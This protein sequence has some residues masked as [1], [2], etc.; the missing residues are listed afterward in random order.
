[1]IQRKKAQKKIH[2]RPRGGGLTIGAGVEPPSSP[3]QAPQIPGVLGTTGITTMDRQ[4]TGQIPTWENPWGGG[5]WYDRQL[6]QIPT[7]MGASGAGRYDRMMSP[8]GIGDMIWG[9][10]GGSPW[11]P[12]G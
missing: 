5:G 11:G 3:E 9:M 4:Q 1:M 2:S 6:P 7:W 12:M 10:G 8:S